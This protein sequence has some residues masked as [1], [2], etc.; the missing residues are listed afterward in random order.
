[1]RFIC[2]SAVA[3]T[4]ADWETSCVDGGSADGSGAILD[5]YAADVSRFKAGMMQSM[6]EYN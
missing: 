2:D 5:C 4:C 6:V 1:M 3:P